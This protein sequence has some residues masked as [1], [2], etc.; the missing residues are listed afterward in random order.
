MNPQNAGVYYSKCVFSGVNQHQLKILTEFQ[1]SRMFGDNEIGLMA[2]FTKELNI[3]KPSENQEVIPNGYRVLTNRDNVQNVLNN[4][5]ALANNIVP[6]PSQSHNHNRGNPNDLLTILSNDVALYRKAI[7]TAQ[8]GKQKFLN[9]K[10]QVRVLNLIK[11]HFVN[12]TYGAD[13]RAD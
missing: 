2:D 4:N 3:L 12:R 6:H 7:Q 9:S 10:E 13:R 11:L 1:I 8:E 5:N